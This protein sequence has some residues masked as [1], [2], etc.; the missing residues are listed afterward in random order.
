MTLL[1]P[2]KEQVGTSIWVWQQ[3]WDVN[4]PFA[5][6]VAKPLCQGDCLLYPALECAY[7][8]VLSKNGVCLDKALL[9]IK[10]PNFSTSDFEVQQMCLWIFLS[11]VYSVELRIWQQV[12]VISPPWIF[13]HQLFL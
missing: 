12:F 4:Q 9:A 8:A 2:F 3:T 5:V 10:S 13:Y 11:S 7:F 6:R 1:L